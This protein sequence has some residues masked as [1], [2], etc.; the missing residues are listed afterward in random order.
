MK[1][2]YLRKKSIND[3][4]ILDLA[5]VVNAIEVELISRKRNPRTL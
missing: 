4:K 5:G 2:K 3:I 1:R